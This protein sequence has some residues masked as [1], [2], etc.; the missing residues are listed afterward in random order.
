MTSKHSSDGDTR[1]ARSVA[2]QG[3]SELLNEVLEHLKDP[4]DQLAAFARA[5]LHRIPQETAPSADSAALEV[6]S[7]FEFIEWRSDPIAVRVFNPTPETHGYESEGSVLEVHVDDSPFLIDSITGE[8]QA[9][10]LEVIRVSHPVIGT[11]RDESGRLLEVMRAR[12]ANTRESVQHWV[13]N[14]FL[15]PVDHESFARR[16]EGVLGDVTLAVGDF[17][18]MVDA[19]ERMAG[20]AGEGSGVYPDDE[21]DEAAA[22]L[23]WLTRDNF[24][25]LGY[26]EYRIVESSEGRAVE[27][28]PGTGLG[29]L[30][31][32]DR[33]RASR[34]LPLDQLSPE[35]RARWE[36]GDL[37]VVSKTN[38][39]STVHRRARMDYVS[40][41]LVAPDGE[42]RGEAR[43][44]GLF[45]AKAYMDSV[46][47]IPVLRRKLAEI[48][49]DE[50]LVEGSHDY[51]AVAE[52]VENYPKDE[53]FGLP[54]EDLRRVVL[55]LLDLEGRSRV[56]LF[57]R[58][59]L[60]DRSVRILV[61]MPRDRYSA[62]IAQQLQDLFLERFGGVS[63]DF[64][65]S[66]GD[67]DT[68]RLHFVV[69]VPE[70]HD[71]QVAFDDMETEVMNV[72]RSWS[73]RVGDI[74]ANRYGEGM[75]HEVVTRWAHRLP[76]Y[77]RA[78]TSIELA[79]GDMLRLDQLADEQTGLLVGI[80][81][82]MDGPQE[83][84]RVTL[85][86][87]GGEIPLSELMPAMEDMGLEVVEEVPTRLTGPGE[88]FIHDFGVTDLA[89]GLV[90]VEEA[91]DRVGDA[92]TAVWEGRA[93]SDSLNRLVLTSGLD[94]E[95]V[96]ILR[97]YHVYW[98][99]VRPVFTV[100]Y[101]N[102]ALL[103]HSEVTADLIDL[104]QKRFDPSS[105]GTGSEELRRDLVARLDAIPS[106]DDDRILH[107]FLGM[108]EATVRTNA[109]V[110]DRGSLAFKF[111]SGDV[112]DMPEPSPFVEIFVIAR[113][114]EGIHLR[115]GPLARGGIRWSERRED[116][117]TEVLGLMKAQV[118]K[119]AIIVP[120]G[121]KG[122]FVIRRPP[123]DQTD[124]EGAV[125][126][127]YEVYI[128]GL[129]DVTDNRVAG[130]VEHPD[131]V[132]VHDGPDPYLVV[133]ADRGTARFSDLAN[134]IAGEYG[135]WLS[136]AF[137]SGGTGGYDHK[138]LGVTA[139]GA[140]KSLESHFIVDG[141]D[142][143]R[144]SFSVVGI[145]DM[146]GDVFGNGMLGSETIKLVAAFDHRHIFIDPQPDPAVS[147]QE[148][149][150]LFALPRSSWADYDSSLL[151]EGG[152]IY[153]RSDKRINL[154]KEAMA[155]LGT[156][157]EAGTPAEVIR[158]ILKAPVDVIW[159][160]GIG[161]FVKASSESDV[162]VGDRTND[163]TRVSGSD[164]R[165][166]IVV[167]GG[168]LGFTQEGRIEYALQGGRINTD[169]IDNSGG[170]DCSDREVNL[171]ILLR[172]A[173]QEGEI[174]ASESRALL[175]DETENVVSAI[176]T[177]SR[178]QALMLT[179][180]R[181]LSES[182]IDGYEQ[183]MVSLEGEG[184]LDR[185]VECLPTTQEM[186]E[187]ARSG[188]AMTR[189][190]L[191][192]LAAHA[193]RGLTD[194]LLG[195]TLPD[196]PEFGHLL[197]TYFPGEVAKRFGHLMWSH[198]LRREL[199]ATLVSNEVVNRQGPVFAASLI[200]RTG[201]NAAA[202]ISAY[203]AARDLV[204]G[205]NARRAVVELLGSIDLRT[206]RGLIDAE[207]RLVSVL[208]R[209]YL[210]RDASRRGEYPDGQL[211][212]FESEADLWSSAAEQR[213]R[214][215]RI[216]GLRQKGVPEEVAHRAIIAPD[217]IH[218]P[219]IL[220]VAQATNRTSLEVGRLFHDVGEALDL[221]RL[222]DFVAELKPRD[223]WQRWTQE[224]L[225]DD[226]VDLRRQIAERVLHG[227]G[228]SSI[229][230]ALTRFLET[231]AAT[232]ARIRGLIHS[233]EVA[234]NDPTPV[235]VIVRQVQELAITVP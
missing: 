108:I 218:V 36:H 83:L 210:R 113:E 115:A 189:P 93:E 228:D 199:I 174:R 43:L 193:K 163:D 150:R 149:K 137:A 37:L 50:D 191:A 154:S 87:A 75:A 167:E 128:R 153:R 21:V 162:D 79:A 173:E 223:P 231:R 126:E 202:V 63:S 72:T 25:F 96:S 111:R 114:V 188:G 20:L 80:Q 32:T 116:Y 28:K 101:V 127:A 107:A 145:G 182:R 58:R 38:R 66:L 33:S 6:E 44:L 82:D 124:L 30:S 13:L 205:G 232:V 26:R 175:A 97:S 165:A 141:A 103:R 221:A 109:Y 130:R 42:T 98:R 159:N 186:S 208:T 105:D 172:L 180:E 16:I 187:R 48:Q 225:E 100:D 3:T 53:L 140:W 121:A 190:E 39:L 171:K 46:T 9:Y 207:D 195:S 138:A 212:Q 118:T 177:D 27:V 235:L 57:V 142:P 181:G 45:T 77:Y 229:D 18:A 209:R 15:D 230:E 90:D 110:P 70:G 69:W 123:S 135:F 216:Q 106:L 73:E 197:E 117:R 183:L 156:D 61:A 65:L 151:S 51:K 49:S 11:S 91:G 54:T 19:T 184:T 68:A 227:S 219:N 132:R 168:N 213:A 196:A 222:H 62:E 14:R 166:R 134:R 84:T 85:Y 4:S 148:R 24:V 220:E 102:R 88:I 78:S 56:R 125:S 233:V 198:P 211:A 147:Y 41:R 146:S 89:G 120:T 94:Y 99:R 144:D 152:G 71:P 161:T 133:A 5:Y 192:V 169:F 179:V 12:E 92:L 17:E 74:L 59:G 131:R 139:L 67:R 112:P 95:Q 136:D 200:T 7:L 86:R 55:G 194:A 158:L 129:L 176:A 178:E 31:D 185:S 201:A 143:R 206:W 35:L 155:A 10:D 76:D 2:P 81:N 22:F 160:G 23:R 119:N 64:E 122:G 1:R 157:T 214:R 224:M 40:V 164:V 29:I 204:G 8:V 60:L 215:Q 170:V 34:P 234:S 47:R 203:L 104:F 226:L 52:L 217:L